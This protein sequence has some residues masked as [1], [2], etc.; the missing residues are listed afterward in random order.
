MLLDLTPAPACLG[1]LEKSDLSGESQQ[2][3]CFLQNSYE[4]EEEKKCPLYFESRYIFKTSFLSKGAYSLRIFIL[5][6]S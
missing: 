6:E 4:K 1:K 3:T 2:R 5:H